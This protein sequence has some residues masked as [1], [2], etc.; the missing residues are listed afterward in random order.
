MA[1]KLVKRAPKEKTTVPRRTTE[2][3]VAELDNIKAQKK[4][5]EDREK[6]IKKELDQVLEVEGAR[7]DKGSYKLIVGDKLATK[8]ARTSIKLNSDRAEEF[9]KTIGI[10]DDVV[11][12]KEVINEDLVEQALT[13][14]AFSLDEF[15]AICDKKVT[16][17]IVVTDYKP[18]EEDG[19]EMPLIQ[20]N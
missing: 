12:T 4:L 10:W 14:E 19:G 1:K 20:P 15:E 6:I 16:Y 18:A 17:A 8:Q 11:E 3:L 2:D 9:F 7:D 13:S 5:L